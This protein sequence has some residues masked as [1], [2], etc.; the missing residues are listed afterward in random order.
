[1]QVFPVD[2]CKEWMF[3]QCFEVP[4][5]AW[6]TS[7]ESPLWIFLKKVHDQ[8]FRLWIK[9]IWELIFYVDDLLEGLPLLARFERKVSA[10]HLIDYDT[11]SPEV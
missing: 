1:M 5:A 11:E 9:L 4:A 10:D 2:P 7:S 8:V 6:R 3:L